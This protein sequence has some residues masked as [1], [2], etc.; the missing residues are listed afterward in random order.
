MTN[1]FKP[2]T[3]L[4]YEIPLLINNSI[5]ANEIKF[6]NGNIDEMDADAITIIACRIGDIIVE[7]M[8]VN[9]ALVNQ[10]FDTLN[11]LLTGEFDNLK[12]A[13]CNELFE[14]INFAD[15]MTKKEFVLINLLIS[16][17][18]NLL[19]YFEDWKTSG[20]TQHFNWI[21]H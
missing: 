14:Q 20:Y 17:K 13:F 2:L 6:Y 10:I 11:D 12:E 1:T 4:L 5:I 3:T 7:N 21:F 18:K 16:K 9:F 19:R 8:N 15:N